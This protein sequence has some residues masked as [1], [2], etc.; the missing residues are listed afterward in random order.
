MN[1]RTVHRL[2]SQMSSLLV[3]M[4]T[5]KLGDAYGGGEKMTANVRACQKQLQK[6]IVLHAMQ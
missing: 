3:D 2:Q 6:L 5:F 4:T 1:N